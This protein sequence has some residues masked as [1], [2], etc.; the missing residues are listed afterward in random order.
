MSKS[1]GVNWRILGPGLALVALLLAILASGFGNDPHALPSMLEGKPAPM[2]AQDT[3]TGQRV[4]LG[5]LKG[6]P[7][8]LNFWSTWCQPCRIEHPWLQEN[9]R[10]FPDVQFY[11]VLYGD[12]EANAL[13][14]LKAHDSAYPTIVDPEGRLAIEYGVAGVPETFFIDRQG[15][16]RHK[17]SGPVSPDVL[18]RYIAE[19]RAP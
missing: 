12:T 17:V 10:A 11:G 4:D 13:R 15:Q 19:L 14:Y 9:A 7:V 5:K 1:R 18:Q 8:I 2:F 16:I 6:T 3:L